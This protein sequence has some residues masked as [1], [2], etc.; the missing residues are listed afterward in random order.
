[1]GLQRLAHHGADG[2]IRNVMVVHHIEV[3]EIG[4]G[5]RH[6]LHFVAEA[7]EVGRQNAGCDA[8]GPR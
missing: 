8:I 2:Q 6:R 7:R 1:M 5:A 3:D 4:A